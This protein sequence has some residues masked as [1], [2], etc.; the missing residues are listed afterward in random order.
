MCKVIKKS[1]KVVEY[2]FNAIKKAVEKSAEEARA[3]R[4]ENGRIVPETIYPNGTHMSDAEWSRVSDVIGALAKR[5]GTVTTAQIHEWIIDSLNEKS[6][7]VSKAYE[8]FH[9]EKINYRQSL[10]KAM[11]EQERA[12]SASAEPNRDNA[13]ADCTQASV[14]RMLSNNSHERILAQK[15]FFS[16]QEWSLGQFGKCV[17]YWNDLPAL[18]FYPYNCSLPNFAYLMDREVT[19]NGTVYPRPRTLREASRKLRTM[20]FAIA[21]NQYGGCTC[22]QCDEILQSHI[23]DELVRQKKKIMSYGVTAEVADRMAEESVREELTEIFVTW[24]SEFNS[25][26]SSRGDYPFITITF[27]L[28]KGTGS[29]AAAAAL[30]V[31]RNGHGADGKRKPVLFPKLVFLYDEAL[32]GEGGQ[33]SWLFEKAKDCSSVTMYPDYLSLTGEGYV[34][35]MYKKYGKAV[36]PMGCRAFLSPWYGRGGMHPADELDE[37]VFIGR[38]NLGVASLHLPLIYY[39]FKEDEE[40]FW[41]YLEFVLQTIRGHFVRRRSKIGQMPAGRNDL[42]F[43]QGGAY[44]PDVNGPALL[45]PEDPIRPVLDAATASFGITGLNELQ[46]AYNG[47]S[48]VEDGEFALKV[49]R[50]INE[51]VAEFKEQDGLLYAIYGTPAESLCGLQVRQFRERYG[52]VPGVSDR[53]YVSNSFHC[54]VT[55]DISP[56]QKQNLENRFWNLANGGKIQ[57][58]KYPLQYNRVAMDTL[59][60]RAMEMG[61]YE[62]CNIDLNFC[63]DCGTRF[64]DPNA[65]LPE[66]CPACGSRNITSINRMNGYMGFSR[67]ARHGAG[68]DY[69]S[70][71]NTRFNAAKMAEIRERVSM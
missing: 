29:W 45:N 1:G 35:E 60:G 42:M 13:N 25:V 12:S 53:E 47:K 66:C 24:E 36:S 9:Q 67:T 7:D 2:D 22:C 69:D 18:A 30:D 37:P 41:A 31:R 51:R 62:G 59:I 4:F 16:P 11:A 17:I 39:E 21:S 15:L 32:H 14:L 10:E 55:E 34:P 64:D 46:R 8:N 38:F 6:P 48:L 19:I 65:P 28:A 33:L 3:I 23:D 26:G 27:G 56:I 54:H 70:F 40:K 63:D 44:N 61:L 5:D 50:F 68:K 57:Y 43:C 58:V 71:A 52:I 20:I 49:M